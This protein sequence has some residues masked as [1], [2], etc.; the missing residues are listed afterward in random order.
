ME[1]EISRGI[2]KWV[3]WE[4]E[5]AE[6]RRWDARGSRSGAVRRKRTKSDRSNDGD[7]C[8]E[9]QD[10]NSDMKDGGNGDG[11]EGDGGGEVQDN[12]EK[13]PEDI[14]D[15]GYG[16]VLGD[17]SDFQIVMGTIMLDHKMG[18]MFDHDLIEENL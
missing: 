7:R 4:R 10:K 3:G 2:G 1:R 16:F 18:G 9:D 15:K 17:Q 12:E 14:V 11:D 5:R 13:M 6:R 8:D